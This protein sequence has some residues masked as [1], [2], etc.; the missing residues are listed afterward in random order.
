[1]RRSS[2][3]EPALGDSRARG[4]RLVL[5]EQIAESV[6]RRGAA[7][8]FLPDLAKRSIRAGALQIGECARRGDD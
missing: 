6:A 4:R 1:M 3:V 8:D 5:S 2:V 7:L